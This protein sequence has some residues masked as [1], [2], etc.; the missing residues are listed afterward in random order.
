MSSLTMIQ[1]PEAKKHIS[2]YIPLVLQAAC[3]FFISSCGS[4][5]GETEN[6][7]IIS[8]SEEDF[9]YDFESIRVSNTD[10]P[11]LVS[12]KSKTQFSGVLERNSSK[13]TT[14]QSYKNGL[15][16]GMSLKRS[17]DGSWV[18]AQFKNGKLH[19]EMKLFDKSGKLRSTI[20]YEDGVHIPAEY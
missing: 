17:E 18:E 15:L 8:I 19:G 16:N 14:T 4:E 13:G 5:D 2:F 1:L 9:L 6:K 12:T 3:C 10:Q 20:N 11:I 7:N